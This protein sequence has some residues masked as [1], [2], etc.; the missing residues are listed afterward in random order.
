[1]KMKDKK[2]EQI[3][4]KKKHRE[5]LKNRRRQEASIERP[6]PI[7]VEKPTI[8]IVCEGKNTEPSYFRKFK[9]STATIKAIG[10][11]Y[12]TISLVNRAYQLSNEKEYDQVW[13]VFDKDDFSL[14]D[15][16]G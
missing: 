4:S 9:L 14:E 13:C 10:E 11:G 15:F 8:L 3:A 16:N 12:N 1:M 2:A 6:E 5:Q 7:K